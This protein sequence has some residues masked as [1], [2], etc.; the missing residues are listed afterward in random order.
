MDLAELVRGIRFI[1]IGN[2]LRTL[3]YSYRRQRIDRRHIPPAVPGPAIPPGKL[4][5]AEELA[6]GAA[7]RFQ[8]AQLEIHFLA[9][10]VV[11][12]TWQPGELPMPYA[13]ADRQWP[14]ATTRLEQVDEAWRL[15]SAELAH[16]L[17]NPRQGVGER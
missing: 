6:N 3:A 5:E 9:P 14:G 12:L 10:D 17:S 11:R 13:L 8:S 1:G 16:A 4:L 7:L 15:S 2:V